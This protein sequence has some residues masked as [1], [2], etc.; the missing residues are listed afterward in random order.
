MRSYGLRILSLRMR[1]RKVLRLSPRISDVLFF[2]LTFHTKFKNL[3]RDLRQ[4]ILTIGKPFL[5]QGI[6]P[7]ENISITFSNPFV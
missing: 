6:V 5:I 7:S 4:E 3:A 1:V 2:P